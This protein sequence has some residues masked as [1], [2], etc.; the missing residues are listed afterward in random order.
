MEFSGKA[1]KRVK[2]KRALLNSGERAAHNRRNLRDTENVNGGNLSYI[3]IL[4]NFDNF[5]YRKCD[6]TCFQ[7]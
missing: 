5:L 6:R 1:K 7:M 2:C 3:V 4:V